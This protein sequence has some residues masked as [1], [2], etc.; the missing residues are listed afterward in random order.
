MGYLR[1]GFSRTC[2]GDN[3]T[4]HTRPEW[5]TIVEAV[6][7]SGPLYESISEAIS[8]CLAGPLR[9]RAIES[10]AHFNRGWTLDLGAGPGVSSRLLLSRGF[11]NVVGL[12]PSQKLLRFAKAHLEGAFHPVVGV[13]ENLPFRAGSFGSV[14]TCFGLRDVQNLLES[15]REVSRVVRVKGGFAVVDVGKPDGPVRRELVWFYVRLGM[16]L[17][18]WLLIRGRIRGNPFRMIIPTFQWLLTNGALLA[19][20]QHEFGPSKLEEFLLGGLIIVRAR[21]AGLPQLKPSAVPQ[22]PRSW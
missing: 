22:P 21:K 19:L 14:L 15:L 20:L 10:L 6:E 5:R 18:A 11:E 13:A 7:E 9:R 4:A 3:S 16:P 12:D 1:T 17:L 8:L 2:S